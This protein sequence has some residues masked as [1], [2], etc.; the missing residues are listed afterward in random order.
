MHIFPGLGWVVGPPTGIG[1]EV[2]PGKTE[3]GIADE[4]GRAMGEEGYKPL[5][6]MG[7]F[8]ANA[9]NMCTWSSEWGR[10]ISETRTL[11]GRAEDTIVFITRESDLLID[12][13]VPEL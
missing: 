12:D 5:G 7:A 13:Q 2:V 3:P 6:R 11:Y 9:V 10:G 4:E 8:I 1:V